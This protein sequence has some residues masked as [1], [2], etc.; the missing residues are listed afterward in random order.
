MTDAQQEIYKV[1]STIILDSAPY[2]PLLV[3]ING[4]DASGKTMMA[5]ALA[6]YLSTQTSREIIR[7]SIDDFMNERA[8]RYT[9][10][11]SAGRGCYDYT[12]DI[13]SLVKYVLKPLKQSEG[14]TYK[15]KVFDH[16]TNTKVATPDK[17]AS[18]DAVVIIDGVFLYRHDLVD[19][20]DIKILLN[21]DDS[22]VIERG[23]TRDQERIG[24][25]E[26]ARRKYIDR[27]IA[28]QT[29]YFSEAKPEDVADIIIDNN[30][31]KLPFVV[32]TAMNHK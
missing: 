8:I 31:F 4:K 21:T 15:D 14:W 27:Y 25:Y 12:F 2:R 22:I 16:V 23:A 10:A 29:I 32:S 13:D 3:A 24:S 5:N 28:S 26:K 20:W 1:I 30:D 6:T 9:L 19:Y 11:D 7:I 18:Q 17:T